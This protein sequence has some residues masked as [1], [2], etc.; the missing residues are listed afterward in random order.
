[1]ARSQHPVVCCSVARFHIVVVFGTMA[2]FTYMVV[3]VIL[4]RYGDVVVFVLLAR[5]ALFVFPKLNF[6]GSRDGISVPTS[7]PPVHSSIS[8]CV[9]STVP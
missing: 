1:M 9:P 3:S 4:A 5:H 8:L 2:R 6:T 7:F